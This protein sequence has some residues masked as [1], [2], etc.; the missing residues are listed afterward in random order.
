LDW[1]SSATTDYGDV[2]DVMMA[3][4]Y[5]PGN[6][7]T[8]YRNGQVYASATSATYGTLQTYSANAAN[9][10]IGKRHSDLAD[11]GTATG[12]DGFLAGSVNE[13]RVYGAALSASEYSQPCQSWSAPTTPSAACR[14]AKQTCCISGH[15]T[16]APPATLVGTAHGTLLN[17]AFV[18]DGRLELDGIDDYMRSANTSTNIAERTLV[19]WVSLDNLS[20][21]A[22]SGIDP[23]NNWQPNVFD[24]IIFA[25]RV[26]TNG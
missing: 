9:F 23:R 25:E 17:G 10:L 1:N 6:N 13:A 14:R 26:P 21:Q 5:G 8:I 11:G 12:V 18:S 16:T 19:V 7:I 3:I 22:G 24:G 2:T 15:S 4:V 20:Q